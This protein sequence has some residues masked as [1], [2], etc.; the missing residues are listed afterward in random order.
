MLIKSLI[1]KIQR[2]FINLDVQN[3]LWIDQVCFKLPSGNTMFEKK[4]WKHLNNKEI[5]EFLKKI[6]HR[7]AHLPGV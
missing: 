3:Y 2:S 7:V 5:S 6:G 1:N 4:L